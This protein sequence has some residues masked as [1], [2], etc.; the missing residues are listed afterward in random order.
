M[1]KDTKKWQ[2]WEDEQRRH[3]SVNFARNLKIVDALYQEARHLK[4]FPPKNPLEGIETKIYLTKV[5]NVR[6]TA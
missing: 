2:A 4:I 1:I 5:L 6:K 3:E